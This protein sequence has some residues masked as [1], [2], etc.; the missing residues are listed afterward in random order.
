M[1][2]PKDDLEAVRAVAAAL[3]G[4]DAKEQERIL[5]WAR[6]KVGLTA[7]APMA[8]IPAEPAP[9]RIAAAIQKEPAE[10]GT[11]IKS[12]VASKNPGSDVQFAATVAYYY[13]FEAPEAER[14]DVITSEDLQEAARKVNRGRFT[15]PSQTLVNAHTQGYLDKGGEK[16][17]YQLNTVG[18]NL[19]S[20]TLP[21]DGTRARPARTR[22][23]SRK[24]STAK[25]GKAAKKKR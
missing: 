14:K 22:P 11:D 13:R 4:F 9:E 15:R 5:R 8:R 20:M 6:E 21:S 1:N 12:F 19:V 7:G 2:K 25:K 17:A 23:K 16:G 24:K 18:E 3:E 10:H